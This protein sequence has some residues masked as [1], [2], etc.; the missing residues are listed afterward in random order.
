[1]RVSERLIGSGSNVIGSGER[2]V[3]PGLPGSLA[4]FRVD[5][6]EDVVAEDDRPAEAVNE[7][8]H[9]IARPDAE[10]VAR[11]VV[12]DALER[13]QAFGLEPGHRPDLRLAAQ[14]ERLTEDAERAVALDRRAVSGDR[15]RHPAA[16]VL[17]VLAELEDV[18]RVAVLEPVVFLLPVVT[19]QE[20]AVDI[21]QMGTIPASALDDVFERHQGT[22]VALGRRRGEAVRWIPRCDRRLEAEAAEVGSNRTAQTRLDA[23]CAHEPGVEAATGRDRIPDVLGRSSDVDLRANLEWMG[24]VRT[25]PC[26]SAGSRR[27]GGGWRRSRDGRVPGLPC[28]R[29]TWR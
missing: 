3:D 1:M 22:V 4:G 26:L 28:R 8:V 23:A 5:F 18:G 2:A 13:G 19:G 29:G 7:A 6:R 11:H 9:R 10:E 15:S 21:A 24:H 27:R 17:Q 14:G 12:D 25:P 20:A 16:E